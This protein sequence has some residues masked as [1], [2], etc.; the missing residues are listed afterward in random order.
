MALKMPSGWKINPLAPMSYWLDSTHAEGAA[1]R[2]AFGRNLLDKPAAE[3]DIPVR[4]SGVGED[5]VQ[6]SLRYYY[7]QTK[8]EGVCKVGAVVF[9]VPINVVSEGGAGPVSL[10]HAIRE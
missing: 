2:T 9:S 5:E 6:V 1:D 4:V 8:D 7:C 3:F 10:V